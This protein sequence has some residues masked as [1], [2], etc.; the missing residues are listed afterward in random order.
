MTQFNS[1][2][3]AIGSMILCNSVN[4]DCIKYIAPTVSSFLHEAQKLPKN[5]EI[6]ILN[7]EITQYDVNTALYEKKIIDTNVSLNL[8]SQQDTQLNLTTD[9]SFW[10]F[11]NRKSI[12]SK[13]HEIKLAERNDQNSKETKRIALALLSITSS[14]EYIKIFSDR[15][16]LIENEILFY[17]RRIKMGSGEYQNK[18]KLQQELIDLNRKVLSA[19]IKKQT[20]IMK[21]ASNSQTFTSPVKSLNIIRNPNDFDCDLNPHAIKIIDLRIQLASLELEKQKKDQLISLSGSASASWNKRNEQNFD[22][23]VA[24]TIPIFNGNRS[25]FQLT[26]IQN[27]L[28]K[29][30]RQR[31]ILL[32][33]VEQAKNERNAI[34]KIILSSFDN[35]NQQINEKKDILD[36]LQDRERLGDTIFLEKVQIEKEISFL[37]EAKLKLS[38]DFYTAW[39]DFLNLYG[40]I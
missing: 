16:D 18:S 10:K 37:E 39:I 4:A 36:Q 20:S 22:T 11:A 24:I 35:L 28:E 30:Q 9:L 26:K 27:N 17:N 21:I 19:R 14:D 13:K 3:L 38:T 2:I 23:S 25:K 31:S 1:I 40:S 8:N 33:E 34:D 32:L 5:S 6:Y 29:L 12:S 15:A 7:R